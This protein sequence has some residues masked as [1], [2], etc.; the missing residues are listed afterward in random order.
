MTES[1][2]PSFLGTDM[3]GM[4]RVQGAAMDMGAYEFSDVTPPVTA[5]AVAGSVTATGWYNSPVTVTLSATDQ[6]GVRELRYVL[7]GAAEVVVAGES[8]IVQVTTDGLHTLSYYAIDR[9]NN[10]AAVK[11][12]TFNIDT[13]SPVT[14]ATVTGTVGTSGWYR[15]AVSLL[16]A[17][18]DATS[19]VQEIRYSIDGGT[20]VV[21]PAA[22]ATVSLPVN[23]VSTVSYW[24][25][26]KA[27]NQGVVATQTVSSDAVAPAV[28]VSVSTKTIDENGKLQSVKINGSASDGLSGIATT[29][30]VVTDK[31]GVVVATAAAFG[32]TVQLRG[33]EDQVYTVTATSIDNAG[34]RAS[35]RATVTVD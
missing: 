8:A 28:T 10:Q 18:S 15:S 21:V 20:V 3:L 2:F 33:V 25:V 35:A 19:G 1:G 4:P 30:I 27:G 17:A 7:D 6:S 9:G 13:V 32:S 14:V 23:K 12:I 16:L 29:S 5:A 26:D 31:N 24:A 34:N 22:S 11:T